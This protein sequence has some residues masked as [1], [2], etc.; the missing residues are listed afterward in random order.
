MDEVSSFDSEDRRIE[1]KIHVRARCPR[2]EIAAILNVADCVTLIMKEEERAISALPEAR[3]R[4][5]GPLAPLSLLDMN[6]AK[7]G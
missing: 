6:S 2:Q 3:C 4:S 5:T 1:I 7:A